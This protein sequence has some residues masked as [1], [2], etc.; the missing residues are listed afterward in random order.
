[1][2]DG[3]QAVG[4]MVAPIKSPDMYGQLSSILGIQQQR[5]QL[6]NQALEIQQNQI[7]TQAAKDSNDYFSSFDPTQW[8]APNG[9]TDV[10][11]IM[12][13]DPGYQK[14][15]GAGKVQVTGQLQAI[16]GKQI[17]NMS[18]MAGM[19]RDAVTNFSQLIG[20][21]SARP[22]VQNDTPE[23]R[24]LL[25]TAVQNYA[26]QGPEQAK[27]AG[28]YGKAFQTPELGGAKQGHLGPAANA[29]AAQAQTVS[30]QQAQS[31]PGDI[32]NAQNQHINRAPATG[33][34]SAPPGSNDNINPPSST[35]AATTKRGLE[36]GGAD[37]DRANQVS[38]AVAPA[39][40]TVQ[41]SK[42]VDDLADQIK[43]GKFADVISKAAAAA[44]VESD[45]YARQLLKKDL[46]KIQS[47]ATAAAPSDLR[48]AT[49]LSGFPDAT[50]DARTIHTAMDYTRGVAR[51]D[52]ARGALLNQVKTKDPSLRGFQ[53]ADD[54]LTS[55]TDPLMH[56]FSALNSPAER[57]AF[58]RRNFSDQKKMEE[59]RDRVA[60]M[61]HLNVI[62]Q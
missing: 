59:F 14:L 33:A 55:S 2:A 13:K 7:K 16:Q 49:I 27:I 46:G 51:Q 18:A 23:G 28:I 6:Q 22:E 34:L 62:G 50:S 26:M 30:Q 19:D 3:Y 45:T 11:G 20:A 24:T 8:V 17:E 15:T 44:G 56:E 43:A 58:Y 39:T 29:I 36:A 1:M 61:K 10:T 54:T 47:T 57:T 41:L 31:N 5:Q 9:T 12:S 52:L 35:V 40:Q 38:A 32:T 48:S 37:F 25:Q 42:Q 53:H 60:G 4:A 21:N